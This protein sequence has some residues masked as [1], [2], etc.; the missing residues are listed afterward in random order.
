MK[1]VI[2]LE[3]TGCGIASVAALAGVS[4]QAARQAAGRLGISAE[5]HRLWS[6][7]THVRRLLKRY[8]FYASSRQRPFRSWPALPKRSLLAIKW[9]RIKGRACWHWVVC[10][11][12]DSMYVL[13]SSPSLTRHVRTDFRRMKPKWFIAV[14][15]LPSKRSRTFSRRN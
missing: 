1:P 8:R 2:Q 7:T 12:D 3:R 14:T 11:K 13:D 6:E 4:Y 15:R 9:R 10:V 5:D